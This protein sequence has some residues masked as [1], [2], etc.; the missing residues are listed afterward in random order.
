MT[1]L[2]FT[3]HS[4][5]FFNADDASFDASIRKWVAKDGATPFATI[6]S[7]GMLSAKID[8]V[9]GDPVAGIP[10][11]VKKVTGC[12]PLPAGSDV[13]VVSALYA[14]AAAKSGLDMSRIYTVADPVFSPDGRTV[15]GC[16]GICPAI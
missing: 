8:T 15:L 1:I 13:V 12:D 7:S 14:A 6:P 5:N 11:F 10:T 9:D 4:L 3:P 2:N 16:R